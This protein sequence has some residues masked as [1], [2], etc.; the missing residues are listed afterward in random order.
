MW[1]CNDEFNEGDFVEITSEFEC[2]F[3]GISNV[4][5]IER[6]L[7]DAT[8]DTSYLVNGFW[9]GYKDLTLILNKA[10]GK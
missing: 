9:F 1:D 2:D 5:I 8:H 10:L 7:H 4:G 3:I 6:V